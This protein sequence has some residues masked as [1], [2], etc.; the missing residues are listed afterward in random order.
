MY[1]PYW[2]GEVVCLLP[3]AFSRKNPIPVPGDSDMLRP[4]RLGWILATLYCL[5]PTA[6]CFLLTAWCRSLHPSTHPPI[7]TIHQDYVPLAAKRFE[8]FSFFHILW[9]QQRL[10]VQSEE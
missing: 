8:A 2:Q 7:S 3:T 1:R 9:P 5:L 4:Y 6:C 10:R